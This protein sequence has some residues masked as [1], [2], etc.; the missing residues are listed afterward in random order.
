MFCRVFQRAAG[1]AAGGAAHDQEELDQQAFLH[2]YDTGAVLLRRH[3][4]A[5]A[6]I[7]DAR[8]D[9]EAAPGHLMRI[10]LEQQRLAKGPLATSAEA[11]GAYTWQILC[12]IGQW[13]LR[14]MESAATV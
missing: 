3:E 1:S 13:N 2:A 14:M 4:Q 8:L 11:A 12:P 10:C 9:A 7:L 5:G 6:P